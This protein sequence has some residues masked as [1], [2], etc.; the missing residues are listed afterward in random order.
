MNTILAIHHQ[1]LKVRQIVAIIEKC[2][3]PFVLMSPFNS[4]A[5]LHLTVRNA[6][7]EIR[8]NTICLRPVVRVLL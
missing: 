7:E 5:K 3:C 1:A 8:P 4:I 2:E 6:S